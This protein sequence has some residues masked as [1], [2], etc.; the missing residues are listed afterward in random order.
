M[1]IHIYTFNLNVIDVFSESHC[2]NYNYGSH[3]WEI[4]FIISQD[5]SNLTIADSSRESPQHILGTILQILCK[6]LFSF[7]SKSL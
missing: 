1:S 5:N 2:E 7:K 4:S 6:S 3:W